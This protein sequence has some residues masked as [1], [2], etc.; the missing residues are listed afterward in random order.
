MDGSLSVAILAQGRGVQEAKV[1]QS[2]RS[3]TRASTGAPRR[4][5]GEDVQNRIA[6]PE[7]AAHRLRM[8]HVH[9]THDRRDQPVHTHDREAEEMMK[10]R[11]EEEQKRGK[12]RNHVH[13]QDQEAEEMI[14]TRAEIKSFEIH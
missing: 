11:A 7:A 8:A 13:P 6:D 3:S 9:S 14:E 5:R 4:H 10:T 2:I 12:E 1:E